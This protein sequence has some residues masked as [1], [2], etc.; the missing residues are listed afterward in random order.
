MSRLYL[1]LALVIGSALASAATSSKAADPTIH[2]K[3]EDQHD[4]CDRSD[5]LTTLR[6]GRGDDRV[7]GGAAAF[8]AF[9]DEDRDFVLGGTGNDEIIGGRDGDLLIGGAGGD[10]F[11][12]SAKSDSP[13]DSAGRWSS[14]A[15]DTIVDFAFDDRDK[16]DLRELPKIGP[17]APPSFRWSGTT[18]QAY[19]AWTASRHGDTFLAV[20]LD[21]N[22][23][24]DLAVR[25]L[26]N[27]K[28]TPGHFCGVTPA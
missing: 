22:A 25:L 3:V 5:E 26:G 18:A 7:Y 13:P 17:N 20:D 1:P 14:E 27:V 15:G 9:G 10:L 2:V 12:Y 11:V 28:L 8:R 6:G 16:I 19:G 24:P 21:G 4:T 23:S